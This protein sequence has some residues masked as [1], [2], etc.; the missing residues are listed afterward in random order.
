MHEFV[1]KREPQRVAMD[2][3]T[4]LEECRALIELQARRTGTQV[5]VEVAPGLQAIVGDAFML[6]QV[7]LNL[8]RNAI[9]AMAD[10]EPARR[11]LLIRARPCEGGGTC[12][13]V[14]DRGTGIPDAVAGQLF[15]PFFTTMT[16]GMGMGLSICRSIV[17]AHG[18]RLSFERLDVGTEF[19]IN[20]FPRMIHI[21]DDEE[22]IRDALAWLLR[23][24]DLACHAH[25]SA[26]DFLA[27]SPRAGRIPGPR[28]RCSPTC[29]W[30]A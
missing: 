20:S 18:G 14:R 28:P 8:T 5:N 7:I 2:V 19:H 30:G 23:S 6:E 4:L 1:R 27:G 21:V 24:R 16:E 10:V 12:I 22:P 15:S 25:A 13:V 17:E 26:E 29:A 3:G 9:E 11:V